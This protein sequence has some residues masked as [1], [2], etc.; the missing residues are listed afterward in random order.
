MELD[1][2][3]KVTLW[4]ELEICEN[5]KMVVKLTSLIREK[6]LSTF[7]ANWKPL[8]AFLHANEKNKLMICRR[9]LNN[10]KEQ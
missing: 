1:Y 5:V 9:I 10:R 7:N 2:S 8:T 4:T 3:S 6:I